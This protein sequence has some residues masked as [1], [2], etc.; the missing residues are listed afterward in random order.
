MDG[1]F[2]IP[3]PSDWLDTPLKDF[4]PLEN[5]LHCDICKEFM[6]TPMITSCCHTF[7]SKCIR[8]CLSANGKCPS[9][10]TADQASKLRNNW[11]LQT[12]IEQ[13][14]EARPAALDV[15]RREKAE[16]EQAKK[17]GKRKRTILDSDDV[18]RAQQDGRTTRSKSRRLA[19]SQSSQPEPIEIDDSDEDFEP[20]AEPDDGL[21]ECLFGCGKRIKPE[22]MDSHLDKC[23]QEQQQAKLAKSRTPINGTSR[24]TSSQ[25]KRPLERISELN[26]S[27]YNDQKL[28]RKLKDVGISDVGTRQLMIR[29]YTEWVNIWNANCD[30]EGKKTQRELLRDLDA[31]E[32]TQGSRAPVANGLS[33]TIMKKDFDGAAWATS[34]KQDFSRLIADAKRRKNNPAIDESKEKELSEPATADIALDGATLPSEEAGAQTDTPVTMNSSIPDAPYDN[35]PQALASIREKVQAAN[36]GRHIEPML[37]AGFENK[38]V[39]ESIN[40]HTSIANSYSPAQ[41]SFEQT[42]F[43][44]TKDEHFLEQT[45]SEPCDF[46]VHI[47]SS[48]VKVPMFAVPQ[49]PVS[50]VEAGGNETGK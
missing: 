27:F 19:A 30:S 1:T 38:P 28:R 8:T 9:C 43:E 35:N 45:T 46:P 2:D 14:L 16:A 25:D 12:I 36:E 22:E 44:R 26:Y 31:W 10:Q 34:N 13:F 50:D 32:R 11:I 3:D 33:S 6:D 49:R 17:R 40:H 48:P 4:S 15:A 7:C 47:K 5:A 41:A 29:R 20:E 18:E 21:V 23:E 37:N 39:S 24:P 42:L